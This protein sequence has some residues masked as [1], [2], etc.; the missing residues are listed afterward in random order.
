MINKQKT[1]CIV[2]TSG[3][4]LLNFRGQFIKELA[5]KGYHVVC[6]S[7]ESPDEIKCI[8]EQLP[9]EYFQVPGDR[10]SIGLFSGLKMIQLYKKAFTEIKPDYC[11]LYMSKPIAFG[12]MAAIESHVPHIYILVNGLE[13]A[14]YR[15]T[16]KDILVRTVMSCFYKHV[17]KHSDCVF[18][19]NHNIYDLFTQKLHLS[20]NNVKV[21]NGSGVDMGYF[22]KTELPEAPVFLMT[23]R[24]LWSKGIREYLAAAKVVKQ[25]TPGAQFLL[26]GGLDHNDEALSEQELNKFIDDNT[27]EYCGYASD[28]RVYISKCSVFVLPSYHEGVPRSVLEAMSMGRPI[29]TT[30]ADGCDDT[31]NEGVNGYKVPAMNVCLLAKRMEELALNGNLRRKMGDWSYKI[32]KEKY[33][34][35]IVNDSMFSEMQI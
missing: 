25:K 6:I 34:V 29:I 10:T 12:G 7:T 24:L 18:V 15:T 19:Q 22:A 35:S 2:A 20:K 23:A 3:I 31:V 13:N 21:I 28:V 27:I 9:V 17:G 11:F 5:K 30:T 4:S 14:Y 26:V 32:C 33:E 8:T 16:L 1:I